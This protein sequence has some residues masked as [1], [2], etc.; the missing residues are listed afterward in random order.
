MLHFPRTLITNE[1]SYTGAF[2]SESKDEDGNTKMIP[3]I[4]I[5]DPDPSGLLIMEKYTKGQF[6]LNGTVVG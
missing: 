4:V 3:V 2:H 5:A 6:A 1:Q